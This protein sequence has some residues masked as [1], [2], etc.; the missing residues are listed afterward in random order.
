M[1]KLRHSTSVLVKLA[2]A[3]GLLTYLVGCNNDGAGCFTKAGE[4]V[5]ALV[6]MD[7]FKGFDVAT[8]VDVRLVPA[9]EQRVEITTGA[10][11]VSGISL[12]VKDSVLYIENLNTCFWSKGY[13]HPLVTLYAPEFD[14]IIQHGYGT[15]YTEDTLMQPSVYINLEDASGEIRLHLDVDRLQVVTNNIGPI[16]LAGKANVF[17]PGVYWSDGVLDASRL[18][19]NTCRVNHNG[20]NKLAVNVVG[21]LTGSVN[22]IGNLYLYGQAPASTEVTLTNSGKIIARY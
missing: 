11:L 8:N 14:K 3:L 12:Q 1:K 15:I 21:V 10:N 16:T 22:S 9:V 5:T 6:E 4:T 13:V 19:A 17:L 18:V 7:E 2:W 20:S